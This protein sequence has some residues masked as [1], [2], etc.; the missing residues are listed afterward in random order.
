MSPTQKESSYI[1]TL[2][3]WRAI[4]IL[5][6]IGAHS[7]S[8]L[9][10]NGSR[11]AM[12]TA[13]LFNHAGF[14]V[15]IFFGLSGYLICTL[16]LREKETFGTIGIS[17]FYIRRAF[18]ILPPV[19]VYL[20]TLVLLSHRG[21]LPDIT[22]TE[23]FSALFFF[24]NY[25]DGSWYTIHFWSLAVEEHFY[26]FA[27]LFILFFNRKHAIRLGLLLIVVCIVVRY[28]AFSHGAEGGIGLR[29][30]NRYD[31]LLWGAIAAL[32]LRDL[33][34][35]DRIRTYL[36]PGRTLLYAALT[37]VL[38]SLWTSP[39]TRRSIVAFVVPWFICSTVLTPTSFLARI[40][41]WSPVRW[42]GR[43]SYSLYIWQ[44]LFL[45]GFV[46]PLGIVQGF[47]LALI[48]PICC[49]VLSYYLVEK[50][51]IKIGHRL[52][53]ARGQQRNLEKPVSA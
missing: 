42:L 26:L 15:D 44:M 46:R 27:P 32:T 33:R 5:L 48:G 28:F 43:I 12:L 24:R 19:L 7:Y 6:V 22:K 25:A 11:P 10:H 49:A 3:G 20:F 38:L 2:D 39:S 36:S 37:V 8:M 47:P 14:G 45:P 21:L 9:Y 30:Q 52:A 53:P 1:P 16:L 50:P 41:E 40:L 13:S 31:G 34:I 29:T 35:K 4:A 18:R 23:V 51:M 17:R